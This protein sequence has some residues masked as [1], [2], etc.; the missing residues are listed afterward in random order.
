MY[1]SVFDFKK[2]MIC[3]LKLPFSESI[4]QHLLFF[5]MNLD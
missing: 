2:L 4:L 3:G 1:N 5:A